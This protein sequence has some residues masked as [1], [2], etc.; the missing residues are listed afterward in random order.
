MRG[1]E[2][3]WG[4]ARAGGRAVMGKGA[5]DGRQRSSRRASASGDKP[6]DEAGTQA[7][8]TVRHL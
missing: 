8:V 2:R 6:R 4:P 1:K 5:G 3:H 7:S